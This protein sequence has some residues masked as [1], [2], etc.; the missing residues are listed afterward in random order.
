MGTLSLAI[1]GAGAISGAHLEA[2]S[3]IDEI[4]VVAIADIDPDRAKAPATQY[5]IPHAR[6]QLLLWRSRCRESQR[7]SG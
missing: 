2:L 5:N 4:E 3:T 7:G 6:R 1:V